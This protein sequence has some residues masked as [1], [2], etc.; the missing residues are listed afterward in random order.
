PGGGSGDERPARSR[1]R[2]AAVRRLA[3]RGVGAMNRPI[4]R[5]FVVGIVVAAVVA[6]VVSQF[7]SS[8][9]DGLEYVAEEQGFIDTAEDHPLG[10]LPLADYGANLSDDDRVNTA[11]AGLVGLVL[12]LALGYGV[13][14][15][16]RRSGS[17]ST[18]SDP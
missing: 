6:V 8:D 10:D 7:A 2:R 9:P 13:F 3:D 12:T 17:R 11:V 14:A 15:L 5:F 16:V 18:A 1:L 4:T